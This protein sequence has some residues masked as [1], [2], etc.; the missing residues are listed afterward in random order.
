MDTD[1]TGPV[2]AS[3]LEVEKR[4]QEQT[5][6]INEQLVIA[7]LRQQELTEA[8]EKLNQQ[9]RE[10]IALRRWVEQALRES[11][12]RSS[13]LVS[14]ITDVTWKF[15]PQGVFTTPQPEWQAYTGQSWEE[16]RHFGW[17]MALHPEDRERV[18]DLWRGAR[19]SHSLFQ[20]NGRI[21]HA[22]RQQ[23][24]YFSAKAI[25]LFNAD[26]KVRE[27]VGAC[28][29]IDAQKRAEEHL[30]ATVAERT[31]QLQEKIGE[32][33]SF[34]YS[35]SHDLRGPL[36]ALRGYSD[37]LLEEHAGAL[38]AQAVQ[39][40]NRIAGA[41]S[42]MDQLITDVLSYSRL[43]GTEITLT[44]IDLDQLVRQILESYPEL[45][46]AHAEISV[47]EKL[48]S[49]LGHEASLT[50]CLSNLLENAVKFVPPGIRPQIKVWA[51]S[52]DI[53]VRLWIEDNGIGIEPKNQERIFAIF[54]RVVDRS[55]YDGTGIGL[56]IVRKAVER[57][58]ARVGVESAPG[59]G[60][61]F[62]LEFQK[63]PTQ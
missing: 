19:G 52:T 37:L 56:A 2:R 41:A 55:V 34:S 15:D 54:E 53:H 43:V 3:D 5:A 57:M 33:E 24:R 26:G 61:K 10:E 16:C 17:V 23:W 59:Q 11:E 51:E 6:A 63:A 22:P 12:E 4:R 7:S 36:R 40:L 45:Q 60:S 30:E 13:S 25:A 21:W 14:I 62:W 46:S 42:R 18:L 29:D 48:P 28:T 38:N 35:I 9:L 39:Y 49:V 1:S 20:A 8:A 47:A 32:L 44:A 31:A 27:W 50:Q 58:K